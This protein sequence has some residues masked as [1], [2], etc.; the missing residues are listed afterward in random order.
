MPKARVE[1]PLLTASLVHLRD[2]RPGSQADR[3]KEAEVTIT[4]ANA[5]LFFGAKIV[6]FVLWD[7]GP[8]GIGVELPKLRFKINGE[9]R[10]YNILRSASDDSTA[11][12]SLKRYIV[13]AYAST[14]P[15]S[16]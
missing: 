13:E 3:L 8:E 4:E 1:S 10:S 12:D 14:L 7:N 2:P 11:L 15:S 6:G 16:D 5:H 9:R